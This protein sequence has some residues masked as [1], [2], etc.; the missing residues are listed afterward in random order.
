MASEIDKAEIALQ[1]E[2][3]DEALRICAGIESKANAD[4]KAQLANIRDRAKDISVAIR[5][6]AANAKAVE[7]AAVGRHFVV[8]KEL[9]KAQSNLEA[10]L[11]VP[12]ATQFEEATKLANLIVAERIKMANESL[13]AEDL[14]TA[15]KHVD[16]AMRV[17]SATELAQARR[18]IAKISNREVA[19]LLAEARESLK[20]TNREDAYAKLEKAL[21]IPGATETGEAKQMLVTIS[22]EL[23]PKANARVSELMDV[24]ERLAADGKFDEAIRTLI[25]A[26]S[27]PHS[28]EREKVELKIQLIHAQRPTVASLSTQDEDSVTHI[29]SALDWQD[30]SRTEKIATATSFLVEVN[31]RGKLSSR[32]ANDIDSY[33]KELVKQIDLAFKRERNPKRNRELFSHQKVDETAAILIVSMGWNK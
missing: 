26:L 6:K 17:P 3:V 27:V 23:K 2:L 33:A 10:A 1:R 28:S 13:V 22:E 30:A 29:E 21:S 7:L 16:K 9:D 12:M 19:K 11:N 14:V 5:K 25:G 18:V 4:E 24:A 31:Q 32:I 8:R 15:K 20:M